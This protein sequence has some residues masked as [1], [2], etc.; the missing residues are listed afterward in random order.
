[1]TLMVGGVGV[2]LRAGLRIPLPMMKWSFSRLEVGRSSSILLPW[3]LCSPSVRRLVTCKVSHHDVPWCLCESCTGFFL[4]TSSVILDF[5]FRVSETS[6][7][8]TLF[9]LWLS[10]WGIWKEENSD[11]LSWAT[12]GHTTMHPG[13]SV[14]LLWHWLWQLWP[15]SAPLS[16][17]P[18]PL[19][20]L[21]LSLVGFLSQCLVN[22][23][24]DRDLLATVSD[25]CVVFG[26]W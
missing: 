8:W 11:E 1:M 22:F 13:T 18:I 10:L 6:L 23:G 2:Y 19:Q 25:G 15:T 16:Y 14:T 4:L 5:F 26:L 9:F 12:N 20:C 7:C 17:L 3:R 24:H 21:Q